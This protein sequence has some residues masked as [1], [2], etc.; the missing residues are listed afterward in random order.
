MYFQSLNTSLNED[1]NMPKWMEVMSYTS[2]AEKGVND[3]FLSEANLMRP[4][5]S[6]RVHTWLKAWRTVWKIKLKFIVKK[7]K[8]DKNEQS[9]DKTICVGKKLQNQII[10]WLLKRTHKT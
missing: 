6:I 9:I 5:Y 3:D 2:T 7:K 8:K 10:K 1:G 4:T